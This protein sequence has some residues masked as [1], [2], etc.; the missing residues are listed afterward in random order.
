MQWTAEECSCFAVCRDWR[1]VRLRRIK[2]VEVPLV[3][4]NIALDNWSIG[5][6]A[7]FAELA[8]HEF[9]LFFV[10]DI[11]A[12]LFPSNVTRLAAGR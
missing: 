7:L 5:D 3:L 12:Q 10:L 9:V 2:A 6:R 4:A 1:W 11:L 8:A